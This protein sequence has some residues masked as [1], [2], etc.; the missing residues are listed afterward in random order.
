[1]LALLSM[2]VTAC[3]VFAPVYDHSLRESLVK[4]RLAELD[5]V[6]RT[7]EVR[8]AVGDSGAGSASTPSESDM[9][10]ADSFEALEE[11]LTP[12]M[13]AVHGPPR[14]EARAVTTF[15]TA[16]V[17]LLAVDHACDHVRVVSGRC[18]RAAQEII[19][20][21]GQA[22]IL[23]WKTG[24]H[25]TVGPRDLTI[26]GTYSQQGDDPFWQGET[27]ALQT[28]GVRVPH[29][30]KDPPPYDTFLTAM[31]TFDRPF[32]KWSRTITYP[33]RDSEVTAENLP[34][35]AAAAGPLLDG[36]QLG[37]ENVDVRTPLP[38]VLEKFRAD[39][40][41]AGVIVLVTLVQLLLL[42]IVV[43]R[44]VLGASVEQRRRE[45]ALAR[46]RGLGQAGARRLVVRELGL[47]LLV[48]VPL[49]VVLAFGVDQVARSW[50]LMDDLPLPLTWSVLVAT[51]TSAAVLAAILLLSVRS[52]RLQTIGDQLRGVPERSKGWSLRLFDAVVLS[53]AVVAVA[54][55]ATGNVDGPV[56]LLTPGVLALA[57]GLVLAHLVIPVAAL[58][59]RRL[60]RRG[61]VSRG[62]AA[63]QIAR[64]P[65]VRRL[66]TV[67]TIAAA[68]AVFSANAIGVADENRAHRA[69][70]EVGAPL[71]LTVDPSLQIGTSLQAARRA[72]RG[73][74]PTGMT[75]TPMLEL[76]PPADSAP[77]LTAVDVAAYDRI[78]LKGGQRL[79]TR[80]LAA[81]GPTKPVRT[82]GFQLTATLS[83]DSLEARGFGYQ[84]WA[85]STH[86]YDS[87]DPDAPPANVPGEF[88]RVLRPNLIVALTNSDGSHVTADLGRIPDQGERP[89]T[90]SVNV[91]CSLGCRVD[92]VLLKPVGGASEAASQTMMIR[93]RVRLTGVRTNLGP[94]AGMADIGQWVD[95]SEKTGGE[96]RAAVRAATGGLGIDWALQN[97]TVVLTQRSTLVRGVAIMS[98]FTRDHGEV[99][100]ALSGGRLQ[101]PS[102]SGAD[103][104][105]AVR[106]TWPFIPGSEINSALVPLEFVTG[107][108]ERLDS[109]TV[110]M[111]IISGD[112]SAQNEHR[113]RQA[114]ASVGVPVL[115]VD[116]TRDRKRSYDRSASA[117]GLQLGMAVAVASLVVAL[118]VI[119][120]AA[121]T[122][123][124]ERSRD[125][126]SL[127]LAG[128][129]VK[130]L[131]RAAVL[132]QSLVVCLAVVLG[133]AAGVV[134]SALSLKRIPLF[135]VP[136]D[137]PVIHLETRWWLV[138]V[139]TVVLGTALVAAAV[140]VAR[141]VVGRAQL[142]RAKE[143]A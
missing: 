96:D 20:T 65:A 87:P 1:M 75:T 41:Q 47:P 98:Q 60:R 114:L 131:R 51:L 135:A 69:E 119:L 35:L 93:G 45:M 97:N 113:L 64:R 28:G 49:G 130:D 81:G 13:A 33:I 83:T 56:A 117:W 27:L 142:A 14:R 68:L 99:A 17:T 57:V 44:L 92:G 120:V 29:D 137:I 3:A 37:M 59:G 55:A 111:K 108:T 46:L 136:P 109:A 124:R 134:G 36:T 84:R 50:W 34:G 38:D 70:A 23:G 88:G 72:V 26:V 90:R 102:L 79:D 15:N 39:E 61:Q 73:V 106:R 11:A 53:A 43:L 133:A 101:L 19:A 128:V 123:W 25:V 7:L 125:F 52:G 6:N 121:V 66:V 115:E 139:V 94:V 112:G 67:V 86:K 48:G 103:G 126:A 30:P 2:V 16:A 107:T 22:R 24:T 105:Y 116:R 91:G 10:E 140:A 141:S 5:P 82:S 100:G 89:V 63:L 138:A 32:P 104:E 80:G 132:E 9:P 62:L 31:Q 58:L 71:V 77:S 18:P 78:A 21:E 143:S 76:F 122:S 95:Q 129:P 12:A 127:R 8:S 118:L 40:D 110:R 54:A 42:L 85:P 74:D 4:A